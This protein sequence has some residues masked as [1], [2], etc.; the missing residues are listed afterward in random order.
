MGGKFGDGFI[1]A[2]AG[3]ATAV[4]GLTSPN[5]Q[6]GQSLGLAG[7]SAIASTVGGTAS[8]IGGGKFANG[9]FTAAFQHLL[10]AEMRDPNGGWSD[11]PPKAIPLD[12]QVMVFEPYGTVGYGKSNQPITG[13]ILYWLDIG[14][15]I[16]ETF[17]IR[18]GGL[19]IDPRKPEGSDTQVRNGVYRVTTW[20]ATR[21]GKNT[22]TDFDRKLSYSLNVDPLNW[23][24]RSIWQ[25][26]IRIHPDGPI[27]N[28]ICTQIGTAGCLGVT[29]TTNSHVRFYNRA[30]DY[31]SNNNSINLHVLRR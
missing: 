16:L 18:T 13:G 28:G 24:K 31:F 9:A 23:G 19:L 15:K 3:A 5:T 27:K 8:V 4:T 14:G 12:R 22:F 30:S 6:I 26:L 10:N 21:P 1:S 11:D 17:D 20:Q 7:R 25:N 2:A 29:N